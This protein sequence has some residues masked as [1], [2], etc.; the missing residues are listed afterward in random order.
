MYVVLVCVC[1]YV[2]L[3]CVYLYVVKATTH[4]SALQRFEQFGRIVH[5]IE[6]CRVC[7]HCLLVFVGDM[8]ITR[9]L[10]TERDWSSLEIQ[11]CPCGT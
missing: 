10:C 5:E 7:I 1:L 9:T 6:A 11:E 2:V 8:K 4:Y 3:V